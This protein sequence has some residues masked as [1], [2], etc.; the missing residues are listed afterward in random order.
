[1]YI[2]IYVYVYIYIYII[3]IIIIIKKIVF[4]S[5]LA[6]IL[7]AYLFYRNTEVEDEEKKDESESKSHEDGEKII[8]NLSEKPHECTICTRSFISQIGLQNHLWSHLP[9]ERRFDGKPILQSQH[10]YSINGVLHTNSDNNSSSNFICP[11]CS[12]K[13]STKG[14]LK[15]HL[16]THRPK[17][18]YGCDICGRMYALHSCNTSRNNLIFI[19]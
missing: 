18:K 13:I 4:I 16:E 11:I 5:V 3:I 15:V 1:M 8:S 10:V 14:N 12:K 2:Y 9:K 19:S 6:Y 17:G 7:F